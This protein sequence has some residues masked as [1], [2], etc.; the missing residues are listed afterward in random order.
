[1]A[2]LARSP[3][4]AGKVRQDVVGAL[5]DVGANPAC[6]NAPQIRSRFNEYPPRAPGS[7][8]PAQGRATSATPSCSG[9]GAQT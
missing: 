1:M 6:C 2:F 7:T 4:E 9:A 8:L 5:R 3:V